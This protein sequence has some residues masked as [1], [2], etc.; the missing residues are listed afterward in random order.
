MGTLKDK[1]KPKKKKTFRKD[2]EG[3]YWIS[4]M[5]FTRGTLLALGIVGFIMSW[6]VIGLIYGNDNFFNNF[7]CLEVDEY[8]YG[9]KMGYVLHKDLPDNQHEV[10]HDLVIKCDSEE[11]HKRADM[12]KTKNFDFGVLGNLFN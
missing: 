2:K 12:V 6:F 9:D 7:T 3:N 8:L 4:T 5:R 11:I 1:D 10:L